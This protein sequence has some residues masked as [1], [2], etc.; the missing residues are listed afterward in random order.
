MMVSW[1]VAAS[2]RL[3]RELVATGAGLHAHHL[4]Q[5]PRAE[6]GRRG[7]DVSRCFLEGLGVGFGETFS[8]KKID[9]TSGNLHNLAAT[10]RSD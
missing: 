4:Q 3:V 5:G 10:Y 6:Q 7:R 2:T 1:G 9:K 8:S